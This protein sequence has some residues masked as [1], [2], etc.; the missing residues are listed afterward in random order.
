M[1]HSQ[2]SRENGHV[3][4]QHK[5]AS[6]LSLSKNYTWKTRPWLHRQKEVKLIPVSCPGRIHFFVSFLHIY[7]KLPP[8]TNCEWDSVGWCSR[9][10]NCACCYTY[11]YLWLVCAVTWNYTCEAYLAKQVLQ[12]CSADTNWWSLHAPQWFWLRKRGASSNKLL[13]NSYV[14]CML[15]T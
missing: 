14:P 6:N 12:C 10:A 3:I 7:N 15:N 5:E 1:L 4:I 11:V 9:Q 13:W 2:N 8:V